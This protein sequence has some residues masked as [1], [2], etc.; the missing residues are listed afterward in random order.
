MGRAVSPTDRSGACPGALGT[1]DQWDEWVANPLKAAQ[2]KHASNAELATGRER[3]EELVNNL[4]P[5]FFLRRTK[6]LIADQLPKKR[7]Q[8]VYC[9][10]T[11]EQ[12]VAYRN[13]LDGKACQDI[14][15]CGDA[16]L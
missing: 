11:A 14:I 3:A 2:K 1:A 5:R 10:M 8:I 12:L 16:I 6:D 13:I 7:D 9:P 4:L 15:Q